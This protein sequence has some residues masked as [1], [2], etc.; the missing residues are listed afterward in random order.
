[1]TVCWGDTF[2]QVLRFGAILQ[3]RRNSASCYLS[4][5]VVLFGPTL[6]ECI[7]GSCLMILLDAV[8]LKVAVR[9]DH[10]YH[11]GRIQEMG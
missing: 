11:E 7:T 10:V 3:R 9:I 1:M 2:V 5:T 4:G 6:K 8:T